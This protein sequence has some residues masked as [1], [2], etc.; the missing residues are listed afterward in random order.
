MTGSQ[1]FVASAP[2]HTTPVANGVLMADAI[3]ALAAL[4]AS[5]ATTIPD[6]PLATYGSVWRCTAMAWIGPRVHFGSINTVSALRSPG[7][8]QPIANPP[9]IGPMSRFRPSMR[10]HCELLAVDYVAFAGVGDPAAIRGLLPEIWGVGAQVSH[11]RGAIGAWTVEGIEAGDWLGLGR[12]RDGRVT[13]MMPT[14]M[15]DD[16]GLDGDGVQRPVSPPYWDAAAAVDGVE[17]A[18][19]DVVAPSW[20]AALWRLGVRA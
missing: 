8:P 4:R 1:G 10:Q 19:V 14:K 9:R 11:G 6:L 2:V 20:D 16:L 18:M 12:G 3:L 7:R 17:P 13:R 15:A 5:G